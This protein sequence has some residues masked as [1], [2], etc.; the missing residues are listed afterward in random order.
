M[1]INETMVLL[2]LLMLSLDQVCQVALMVVARFLVVVKVVTVAAVIAM[3]V[4]MAMML[5]L[6]LL[7]LLIGGKVT[8]MA[9]AMFGVAILQAAVATNA[10]EASVSMLTFWLE[11]KGI[12]MVIM[13]M[14]SMT[15]IH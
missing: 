6:L 1:T 4:R 5:W 7:L 8:L 14:K 10:I 2:L 9:V 13:M 3:A 11:C 15:R 12:V